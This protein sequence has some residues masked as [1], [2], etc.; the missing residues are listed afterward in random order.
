MSDKI[1]A[2]SSGAAPPRQALINLDAFRHNVRVLS[3]L[4]APAE[5]MLAVKADAYGHGMVRLAYAALE[6]GATSLAV[7]D[8]P[9]ALVLRKAGVT[10][11]IFAWMHAPDADFGAAAESDIDLG[12]SAEWQIEAIA[13]ARD[14]DGR[15]SGARAFT[16]PRIHLKIDTGLHRNGASVEQ[17]PGLVRAALAA[18]AAGSVRLYAAWS[19]LADASPADDAV[20]LGELH[21]AVAVAEGL[22][23]RFERVHLAASSAGIRMPEARLGMVRFG[24]A[25]YGVTPFD[26]ESA[27]ELGLRPVMTLV[28]PVVSVKRVPAGHGVS[29]GFDYRTSRP[30]TLVLVPLGYADGIPRAANGHGA[31]VWI[32]GRRYP[33]AGRIAMDQF[34]VDVGDADVQLG[35]EVVVFGEGRM[36]GGPLPGGSLVDS[37]ASAASVEQAPSTAEPATVVP[38]S[39]Q[40]IPTAEEWAGWARTIGDEIVSRVGPRVPRVYVTD[41][42]LAASATDGS[43]GNRIVS[44]HPRP[45]EGVHIGQSGADAPGG[46]DADGI[47]A[48]V[49][50][51]TV[52]GV[53]GDAQGAVHGDVHGAD[54]GPVETWVIG[55]PE[56]MGALGEQFAGRLGAGDVLVLTG[57]LGA[58]KTTFTR[59][60]GAG[61]GVRGS[62]TSPTFVLART[63]PNAATGVPLV[64]VDA[65]RLDGA[66]QLDDLD[67][68]FASSIVVVEWGAGMIEAIVDDYLELVIERPRGA[69]GSTDAVSLGDGAA[70]GEE[71]PAAT[72]SEGASTDAAADA[73]VAGAD[74]ESSADSAEDLDEPVEPRLVSLYRRSRRSRRADAEGA[75]DV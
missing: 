45:F 30:S 58:G 17:W 18:D 65:Y 3:S 2:A 47:G 55:D 1:F 14:V 63:H 34:I 11:P 69:G 48:E 60:L 49:A 20:A 52:S 21:A 70:E 16:P 53:L 10:A 56:A 26:D 74:S 64:H 44:A 62:V 54:D 66:A 29:Y 27:L 43:G 24:I 19:H 28:A 51:G 40:S 39:R 6:A 71:T 59:G 73:D 25:A 15:A 12:I 61:L 38:G 46:A 31:Q 9:A 50:G 32:G 67:I 7:L 5:T 23:A 13:A 37:G 36:P 41:E 57:E 35:D 75:T 4:A 8:I 72:I 42:S 33:V 68:D 22:G